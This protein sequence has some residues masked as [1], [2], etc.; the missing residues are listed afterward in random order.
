[1]TKERTAPDRPVRRAPPDRPGE[2]DP[3]PAAPPPDGHGAGETPRRGRPRAARAFF[4]ALPFLGTAAI[5]AL[6]LRRVRVEELL[7]AFAEAD[8]PLFLAALLPVSVLYVVFDAGLLRAV[9]G[10]FHPPRLPLREALSVRA[11]DYLVSL[12]NGRASQ[13]A[14]LGL[15]G[16]R[17]T[18]AG[19]RRDS[20]YLECAGTILFLD[21]GH[22]LHLLLWAGAGAV[23]V[24]NAAP[25]QLPAVVA[26][27]IVGL[28]LLA[29]FL[30]G[31]LRLGGAGVGP[32]R[33]R[34]LRSFERAGLRRYLGVLAWKAPPLLAAA[35]GHHFALRAFR[36]E[37]PITA[38]LA[39]LPIIFLAAAL[40]ITVGR[41]GTSQAAWLYLHAGIAAASPGGEPGLLAYSLA[42]H[43]TFLV[44]NAALAAP[45][46]PRAW[47]SLRLGA[48]ASPAA[49]PNP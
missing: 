23:A 19:G 26:V 10:W 27:G 12:W 7:E 29:V 9:L 21:L 24:G 16:R 34:I 2:G 30:R 49:E 38:L 17:F 46:L 13:A 41:L 35:V 8:L 31:R 40:P 5:L 18:V 11:V 6:L 20:G 42:A 48:K 36:V 4:A 39:T 14:L 28:S 37:I 25:E 15:L 33:W 45:F 22:R 47:R 43:L 3:Q 44:A 1:M 32:P